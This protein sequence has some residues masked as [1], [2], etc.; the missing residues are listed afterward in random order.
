MFMFYA[1]LINVCT[2]SSKGSMQDNPKMTSTSH[3]QFKFF[4]AP[5][6]L[7]LS[8]CILAIK[9][10]YSKY[11][12]SINESMEIHQVFTLRSNLL[13]LVYNKSTSFWNSA[14]FFKLWTKKVFKFCKKNY[15]WCTKSA[16]DKMTMTRFILWTKKWTSMTKGATFS[17][18]CGVTPNLW[19]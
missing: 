5:S 9:R 15:S 6:L 17:L 18:N 13:P 12:H 4:L 1:I 14:N 19:P 3:R 2:H 16:F 7:T 11:T 10:W 8:T